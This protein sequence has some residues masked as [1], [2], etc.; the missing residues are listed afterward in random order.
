M[1]AAIILF[2]QLSYLPVGALEIKSHRQKCQELRKC[3]GLSAKSDVSSIGGKASWC[4]KLIVLRHSQDWKLHI[5]FNIEIVVVATAA[6]VRSC[7]PF[8]SGWDMHFVHST[9]CVWSG[10]IAISDDL[11]VD[12]LRFCNDLR[13]QYSLNSRIMLTTIVF[14]FFVVVVIVMLDIYARCVLKRQARRR[15]A[16]CQLG[17]LSTTA[18]HVHTNEQPKRGL[19]AAV[20]ATL[21]LFVYKGAEEIKDRHIECAIE[22]RA[23]P[24]FIELVVV[25]PAMATAPPVDAINPTL[26]CSEDHLG[27]VKTE[28]VGEIAKL[29]D[30]E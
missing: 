26:P 1:L 4:E 17:C 24:E 25:V 10:L 28:E 7:T 15:E 6:F 2:H 8:S 27:V 14:L 18:A 3:G 21:P 19:D 20:I 9:G 5:Y 23:Q 30:T 12:V 22:P 11:M 13:Y 29:G 16:L